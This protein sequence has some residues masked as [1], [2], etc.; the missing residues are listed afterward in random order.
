MTILCFESKEFIEALLIV[1][2][3]LIRRSHFTTPFPKKNIITSKRNITMT[4]ICFESQEFIEA[5]HPET[6][7]FYYKKTKK[8]DDTIVCYV[9]CNVK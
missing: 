1:L 8:I 4:I 3:F 5:R 9:E 7:H 2:D 6:R